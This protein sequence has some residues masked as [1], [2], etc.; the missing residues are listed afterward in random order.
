MTEPTPAGVTIIRLVEAERTHGSARLCAGI[1]AIFEATAPTPIEANERS[2]FHDLWLGDY[3]RFDRDYAW[4]A[5]DGDHVAGYLVGCLD[6]AAT[7]PRFASLAYF[8]EFAAACAAY[9]A[10]LHINLDGAFRNRG[11]GGPLIDAFAQQVR[12][13]GRPGMHV[14]TAAAAR[15]VRFYERQGF[16]RI[17]LSRT[18]GRDRVFLGRRTDAPRP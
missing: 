3:L 5:L 1:D 7:S 4:L 15:N 16:V 10:H 8:Q 2:A 9:P 6:N 12:A 18:G 11:I 13:A 17:A 14:V